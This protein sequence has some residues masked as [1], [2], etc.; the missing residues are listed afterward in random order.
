[1]GTQVG[2]FHEKYNLAASSEIFLLRRFWFNFSLL[3]LLYSL[4]YSGIIQEYLDVT[5][6]KKYTEKFDPNCKK[7]VLGPHHFTG[8]TRT[9]ISIRANSFELLQELY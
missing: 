4:P 3:D 5:R 7:I 1:M 9:Q 8:K 6:K 2:I